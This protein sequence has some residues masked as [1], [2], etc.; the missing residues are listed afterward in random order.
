MNF[1]EINYG[2]L[3]YSVNKSMI[4]RIDSV[5]VGNMGKRKIKAELFAGMGNEKIEIDE[6]DEQWHK[7]EHIQEEI[8]N[9]PTAFASWV[10]MSLRVSAMEGQVS[11]LVAILEKVGILQVQKQSNG[12]VLPK[13]VR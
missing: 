9:N 7:L 10:A 12:L 5:P 11:Q 4:Y 6:T 1:D 13:G 8:S 2:D 3:V